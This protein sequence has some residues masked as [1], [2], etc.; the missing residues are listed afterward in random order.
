VAQYI[1]RPTLDFSSGHDPQGCG[2]EPHFRL[3]T[4]C[5]SC[6]RILSPWGTQAPKHELLKNTSNPNLYYLTD[7]LVVKDSGIDDVGQIWPPQEWPVYYAV[8]SEFIHEMV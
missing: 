7:F 6:F 5:G 2:I 8:T 4:G 1:K 3:L